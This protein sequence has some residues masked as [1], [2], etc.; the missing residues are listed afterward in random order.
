MQ[1]RAFAAATLAYD[2]DHFAR[3]DGEAEPAK[4]FELALAGTPPPR[5]SPLRR[6]STRIMRPPQPRRRIIADCIKRSTSTLRTAVNRPCTSESLD[7]CDGD[8]SGM[9]DRATSCELRSDCCIVRVIRVAD[10]DVG[11]GLAIASVRFTTFDARRRRRFPAHAA[12]SSSAAC[13]HSG[14]LCLRTS[15]A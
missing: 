9:P 4:Q 1:Q 15:A 3:G 8:A 11:H 7:T 13:V 12:N 5:A 10:L 2:R 14:S 6:P